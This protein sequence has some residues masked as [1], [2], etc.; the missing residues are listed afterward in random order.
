MKRLLITTAD[1]NT[2]RTDR[3]VLFLGE[4]CRLYDRR[5]AWEGLDAEVVPYHWDDRRRF[6]RDYDRA[7][8]VYDRLLR[9]SSD[10]LN[11]YHHTGHSLRYWRTLIGQWLF[12]LVHVLLDR[13]QVVL[14]ASDGYDIEETLIYDLPPATMISARFAG[15]IFQDTT[16]NHHLFG[17]VIRHQNRIRWR[18]VPAPAARALPV[19]RRGV[20]RAA[21]TR[22]RD[23]TCNLLA[24]FT[25]PG[26][27]LIIRSY[28][29]RL[30]EIALQLMLG[31]IPKAWTP[32]AV[33]GVVPDM[34]R[35]GQFVVTPGAADPFVRFAAAM[36]PEQ[37]PTVFLEGYGELRRAAAELPWP[38]RPRVIF[39]SNLDQAN[40]VFQ[41][42]S[43][44]KAEA[45]YPLVI[46]QHG[47]FVGLAKRHPGE[48]DQRRIADR[49][50][51]WGWHDSD[52]RIHP[53]A[54]LTNVG[55]PMRTWKASGDLLLV[56][57]PMRLYAFRCMSTPVGATQSAAFVGDQISFGKA[58]PDHIRARLILRIE[59]AID[60]TLHTCYVSRWK[61]AVP[62]L[63]VD[64]SVTP[65]ERPLRRCRLFV[66]TYNS[67]GFLETLARDIPT[68]VFWNPEYF[69]LRAGAQPYFDLLTEARI[70][71]RTPE[72]AARH[73]SDIWDDVRGWWRDPALQRIREA[74]CAQYARMPE[75]PLQAVK[76]AL[77]TVRPPARQ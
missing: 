5:T 70:F 2:W 22:L 43:A 18:L 36:I 17:R 62:G 66:Y 12:H 37:I 26:E 19:S 31:Q 67:T 32:P 33:P 51:S 47:G 44:A 3:P 7:Q 64:P 9:A 65:I 38:P 4:W 61:D 68:V 50:L 24:R 71:H 49:Y 23:A 75:R 11:A 42:W 16:W 10:A 76:D 63:R 74:F 21:R 34:A 52:V 77:L 57:V 1:E 15:G 72:S 28:L 35:R 56:T 41:E 48:D 20:R 6:D 30:Q 29:P 39:T 59:E 25:A 55:K 14:D 45:G 40:E 8:D 54:A 73:V 46:G 27:P 13:W 53:T 69:E 60:R 58:L